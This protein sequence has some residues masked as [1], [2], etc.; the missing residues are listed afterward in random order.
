[1]AW[2][3]GGSAAAPLPAAASTVRRRP[4]R[5]SSGSRLSTSL[6]EPSVHRICVAGRW[7]K[8][9]QSEVAHKG[10]LFLP[11]SLQAVMRA[12]QRMIHAPSLPHSPAPHDAR[13]ADEEHRES[14]TGTSGEVWAQQGKRARLHTGAKL[15]QGPGPSPSDPPTDPVPPGLGTARSSGQHCCKGTLQCLHSRT[16]SAR[17]QGWC[18][19]SQAAGTRRAP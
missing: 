4:V 14:P 19:S 17:W 3:Q 2:G 13:S 7:Q 10:A 15:P 16:G 1:V 8:A 6:V 18:A 5:L 12:S 11:P 9:A